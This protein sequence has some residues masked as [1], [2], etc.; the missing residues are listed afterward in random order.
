MGPW[1]HQAGGLWSETL[2]FCPPPRGPA[3]GEEDRWMR[4]GL[5]GGGRGASRQGQ[6]AESHPARMEQGHTRAVRGGQEGGGQR[7]AETEAAAVPEKRS[8]CYSGQR[9]AWGQSKE[10]SWASLPCAAGPCTGGCWA[11]GG[12]C[13]GGPPEGAIW[14]TPAISTPSPGPSSPPSACCLVRSPVS[15][16]LPR[17][18]SLH[19]GVGSLSASRPARSGQP[20]ES[21][22]VYG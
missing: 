1:T 2:P 16:G 15:P 18:A 7:Q 8:V 22:A 13:C 14:G 11:T 9:A 6:R 19:P 10:M 12:C 21:P 3:L 5:G 4:K 17:E 20:Q